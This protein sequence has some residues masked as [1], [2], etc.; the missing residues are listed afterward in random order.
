MAVMAFSLVEERSDS[1]S[2][3][4]E[5]GG[6]QSA[7]SGAI[8]SP[9]ELCRLLGL[10]AAIAA[11]AE[12]PARRFPMLVP[13]TLLGR[14]GAGNPEDPI[15]RQ[16]MPRSDELVSAPGFSADPL[17][18]A[19]ET[20][21][22]G[23]LQ[24]YAGR[25]LILAA[26]GCGVHCRYCFRRH[27]PLASGSGAVDG[28]RSALRRL[29]GDPSIREVI[30]SGGDPLTLTDAELGRLAVRLAA[31]RHLRRLRVHTRLPVAVPSRVGP[32]LLG[33]L[34]GTRLTPI[35]VLQVN[36]AAELDDDAADALSELADAGVPLLSQSV[37]L[38]G[39]NDS[40]D[41][42]AALCERLVDL[43]IVPYY[44][45]QL[46]RVIGAGH[47][48]VPDARGKALLEA[49]RSRLP[50]YAVPRYVRQTP[51]DPCKRVLA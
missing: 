45:H 15:L 25:S 29:A 30:L 33:W 26:P 28:W 16:V 34:R 23:L 21:A 3:P 20:H 43:R 19:G 27:F 1:A 49:V 37:L 12:E 7:L 18:E 17:C 31:I 41:A 8:R 10:D 6:W 11:A 22:S 4:A 2:A 44:L 9:A 48:E 35:V 13:R 14:I 38:R 24:K 50:G 42:L 51:S 36:H 39:V 5:V 32:E 47:F 46:D 40:V